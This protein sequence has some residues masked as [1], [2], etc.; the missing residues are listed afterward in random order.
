MKQ[1]SN[2][3]LTLRSI[4]FTANSAVP[5][6][7]REKAGTTNRHLTPFCFFGKSSEPFDSLFPGFSC[8]PRSF[9]H[10]RSGEGRIR[11]LLHRIYRALPVI[12]AIAFFLQIAHSAESLVIDL[13]P[14]ASV[15]SSAILLEDVADLHGTDHDA[16]ERLS[17]VKL[18]ESPA[19]GSMKTLSRQQI[20]ECI[21]AAMGQPD[22]LKLSGAAAV[23]VR[24]KGIPVSPSEIATLLKSYIAKMTAWKESEIEIGAI[25]NLNGVEMPP[26]GAELRFSQT[27]AVIGRGHISAS[28][29][30]AQAGKTM[31]RFWVNADICIHADA[32]VA[33]NKIF[34]GQIVKSD[35]F[36]KQTASIDDLRTTYIANLDEVVGK[37]SRRIFSP[38]DLI[39]REAFTEVFL[40]KRGE[41]VQLQLQRDGIMLTS[42]ARA[43]EDGMLGQIIR[44]RNTEFSNVVKAQVT[45]RSQVMLP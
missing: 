45:G 32:W 28:L 31:R 38:G 14:A 26:D 1:A 23:Q 8:S 7:P 18:G 20:N 17:Q 10:S 41:T 35:D 9:V 2:S 11:S 40:I 42:R 33:A 30:I 25:T 15:R 24:M 29:E 44:V 13:K 6:S 21:Q 16:I 5:V 19:L 37:T 3:L 22:G 34:P 12:C 36:V 4:P 39:V 43:E 27:P